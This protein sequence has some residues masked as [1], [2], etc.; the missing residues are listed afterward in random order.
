MVWLYVLL[1]RRRAMCGRGE[2][3]SEYCRRYVGFGFGF[4]I[5]GLQRRFKSNPAM[6]GGCSTPCWLVWWQVV[7]G[8]LSIY[9][10]T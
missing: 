8:R 2:V 7:V 6:V 4:V 3:R 1:G 10:L 9:R 5:R